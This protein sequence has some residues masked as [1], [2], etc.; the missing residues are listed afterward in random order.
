[1]TGSFS[2][3]AASFWLRVYLWAARG[4]PSWS[5]LGRLRV[6]LRNG[7]GSWLRP[8]EW[9][10]YCEAKKVWYCRDGSARGEATQHVSPTGRYRLTVTLHE[11][12][13]GCWG[14]TKG[15][16]YGSSNCEPVAVVCRNYPAFPF[17]WVE[18]HP[19]GHDYLVCGAD[20]Q[21]QTI[22]ELDTGQR[23]DYL[24]SEA[25]RGAAFCWASIE[26]SP[27]RRTLAVAGC[28][29]GGP[30]E[31]QLVDFDNP[32]SPRFPVLEVVESDEGAW[33]AENPDAWQSSR[34]VCFYELPDGAVKQEADVTY[35]EWQLDPEPVRE[36]REPGPLWARI[37]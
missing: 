11:T 6:K 16:A 35:E 25:A 19:N 18:D 15:A 5:L 13:P 4:R 36:E 34:K 23:V 17:A 33:I 20:Y 28:I 37:T 29:W 10:A 2:Y 22:V 31:I 14:Y 30:F 3:P 8:G 27:S 21:G 12:E 7:V 9:A 1:M 24:P 26:P 32:M